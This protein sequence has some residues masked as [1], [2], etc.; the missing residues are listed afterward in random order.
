MKLAI[1]L[2]H[3]SD[4]S[5]KGAAGSG[6]GEHALPGRDVE[7][8]DAAVA[9]VGLVVG[10]HADDAAADVQTRH[11]GSAVREQLGLD[12]ADLVAPVV[13]ELLDHG[14]VDDGV[15]HVGRAHQ[16]SGAEPLL[17]EHLDH[18]AE[19]SEELVARLIPFDGRGV[20][21]GVGAAL[22]EADLHLVE[23][24]G[25][26]GDV[27]HDAAVGQHGLGGHRFLAAAD[28][29][30]H[31]VGVLQDEGLL[32]LLRGELREQSLAEAALLQV[33]SRERALGCHEGRGVA[34]EVVAVAQHG[35]AALA[36]RDEGREL[37]GS[38]TVLDQHVVGGEDVARVVG[39]EVAVTQEGHGRVELLDCHEQRVGVV[40]V[41]RH[42]FVLL[43]LIG[44]RVGEEDAGLAQ[45]LLVG[46]GQGVGCGHGQ[47]VAS[48][49][50]GAVCGGDDRAAGAGVG[51]VREDVA[52]LGHVGRSSQRGEVAARGAGDDRAA[53]EHAVGGGQLYGHDVGD[54]LIGDDQA[55][56][57]HGAEVFV[58]SLAH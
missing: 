38:V 25:V 53:H 34:L 29:L 20:L 37:L 46:V 24:V 17:G 44:E 33:V 21:G 49:V 2:L 39:R 27:L 48:E 30:A 8:V 45:D 12:H 56:I 26:V 22:V 6:G 36:G 40:E 7:R 13:E 50:A 5:V 1:G 28:K 10:D 42:D 54:G 51:V 3:L 31:L 32:A 18:E 47:L 16:I 9:G 14:V 41:K 55:V 19:V 52:G 43:L 57:F 15:G 11:H 23:L 58:E 4:R 35:H